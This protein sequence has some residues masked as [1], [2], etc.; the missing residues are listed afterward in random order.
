MAEQQVEDSK[1]ELQAPEPVL[2]LEDAPMETEEVVVEDG[3]ADVGDGED[4]FMGGGGI[5]GLDD[6]DDADNLGIVS[7]FFKLWAVS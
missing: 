6:D 4:F 7:A 1:F 3:T 5:P 2:A